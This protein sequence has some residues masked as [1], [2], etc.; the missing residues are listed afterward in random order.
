MTDVVLT[1]Q[2]VEDGKT[3]KL[4]DW[5]EELANRS[6]EVRET[7]R[8]EGMYTETA[9]LERTEDGHYLYYYM[10]AEDVPAALQAFGESDHDVDREH[11]ATMS[12]VVAE[13]PA[14]DEFEVLYHAVNPDRPRE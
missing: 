12:D 6:D 5:C 4:R 11:E 1:R 14:L 10:E 7:L 2:R 13:S 8:D 9:F 3:E